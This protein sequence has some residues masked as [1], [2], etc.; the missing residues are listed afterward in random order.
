MLKRHSYIRLRNRPT[1][2]RKKNTGMDYAVWVQNSDLSD[3]ELAV[4]LEIPVRYIKRMRRLDWILGS[5]SVIG[6]TIL[7]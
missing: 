2:E 1:S 7:L 3:D 6:L 5:R 4:L